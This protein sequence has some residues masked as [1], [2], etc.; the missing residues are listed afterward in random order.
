MQV[1][2]AYVY[3]FILAFV[4]L[5]AFL[6]VFAAKPVRKLLHKLQTKYQELFNNKYIGYLIDF[7]FAIIFLILADSLKTFYVVSG[8][9]KTRKL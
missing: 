6:V 5:S 8:H 7:S 1:I 4:G 3:Y 2:Y 9:I